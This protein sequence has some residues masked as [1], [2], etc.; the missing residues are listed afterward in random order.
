VSG[1]RRTRSRVNP[2]SPAPP[3]RAG[4]FRPQRL[5]G[6]KTK[7]FRDRADSLGAPGVQE[8]IAP[9]AYPAP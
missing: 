7:V 5:H 8:V 4:V 9:P 6:L 3:Q 2:F 1:L